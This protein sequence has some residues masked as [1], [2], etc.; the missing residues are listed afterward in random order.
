MKN[1]KH[2]IESKELR[3]YRSLNARSNLFI[4][5]ENY[6]SF[7]EKGFEGEKRFDEMTSKLSDDWYFVD[8]LLFECNKSEFQ[9]D[10]IGTT[11]DALHFFEVKNFEGD[12]YIEGDRWYKTPKIEIKNPYEQ[13]KRTESMLRKL[14][15][16]NKINIRIEPHLVFVNPDFHLFHAPMNLPIIFPNQ[17]NR[18]MNQLQMLPKLNINN[19]NM[20][21]KLLALHKCESKYSQFPNYDYNQFNK[22]FICVSCNS[23]ITLIKKG[24]LVC[25]RCGCEEKISSG[26]IRSAEELKFLFPD[27]KITTNAVY[28]WCEIFKSKKRIRMIL[29][30]HFKMIG[31]GKYSYFV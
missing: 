12:Y 29:H 3:L 21:E 19:I 17:L 5:D 16:E 2:R 25:H 9:I 14:L 26:I 27:K 20:L 4:D 22:G 8:D 6:L 11:G 28:E 13:L 7:L 31:H 15:Y 30:N 24:K 23:F 10:S 1:L 18:F